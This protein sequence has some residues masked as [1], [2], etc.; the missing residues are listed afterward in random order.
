M[1][2]L[3]AIDPCRTLRNSIAS[4]LLRLPAE[5]RN[6]IWALAFGNRT[7]HPRIQCP[8]LFV[9]WLDYKPSPIYYKP[10]LEIQSD[11]DVY[12]LSVEGASVTEPFEWKA[13]AMQV[14]RTGTSGYHHCVYSP[15]EDNE[16]PNQCPTLLVPLVCK[17][18]HREANPV[19]WKTTVF[20]FHFADDFYHFVRASWTRVDLVSQLC[21]IQDDMHHLAIHRHNKKWQRA[22]NA[23][24]LAKFTSLKGVS[25]V[26]R[27]D[28]FRTNP[29]PFHLSLDV[30]AHP[31][32]LFPILPLFIRQFQKCSL[33]EEYTTVLLPG[34]PEERNGKQDYLLDPAFTV[35]QRREMAEAI[36]SRLLDYRPTA[37]KPINKTRN[38]F[39]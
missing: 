28:D 31:P 22:L 24:H 37:V 38:R 26:L 23:T 6:Y 7:V 36:R 12:R 10:C 19:A 2:Y 14:G 15:N 1:I 11:I 9:F 34:H 35:R 8:N 29:M 33:K 25:L 32:R 16:E 4:P 18:L 30:V 17:Q 20:A 21:V 13:S 39:N 3:I 27:S 5:L